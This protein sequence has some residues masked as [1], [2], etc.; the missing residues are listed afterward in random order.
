VQW[1]NEVKP[2]AS[3]NFERAEMPSRAFVRK[4]RP[5]ERKAF[6]KR[7]KGGRR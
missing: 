7:N 5:K 2:H 6:L 3:L 4:L 1:Y